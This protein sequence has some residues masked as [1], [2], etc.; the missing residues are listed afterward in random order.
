MRSLA[1]FIAA[2]FGL[3]V[4]RRWLWL[5]VLASGG[6]LLWSLAMLAT[7]NSNLGLLGGFIAVTG[8]GSILALARFEETPK[9]WGD[10]A[11]Y[12]PMA[13]AFVQLALLLPKMDYSATGWLFYFA[14]SGLA[15]VLAWRD[16]RLLPLV[17][18]ALLL[19]AGPLY[20]AWTE[21]GASSFTV[22]ASF[23]VAAL[24]V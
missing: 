22:A 18:G 9:P 3:A 15:I 16:G 21:H 4:W 14:L 12:A 8:G 2:L 17:G 23:A 5:L 20:G 13:L 1:V 7:A 6:G 19:A 11:R 10:L 24:F